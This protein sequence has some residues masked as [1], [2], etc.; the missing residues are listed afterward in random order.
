M[1]MI[2]LMAY[3]MTLILILLTNNFPQWVNWTVSGI[4]IVIGIIRLIKER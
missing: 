3:P 1:N 4:G 2:W